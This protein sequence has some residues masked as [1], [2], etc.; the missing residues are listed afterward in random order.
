MPDGDPPLAQDSPDEK[1]A[2][3]AS[4]VLFATEQ[5]DPAVPDTTLQALDPIEKRLGAL[6]LRIV[7]PTIRIIELL[8][9]GPSSKLEAEEHTP[10]TVAQ[11]DSFEVS[12][13]EVRRVPRVRL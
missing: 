1:P 5:G 8:S 10:D 9:S 3:A 7:Y 13:A 2:V 12:G 6:D 11:Q 4:W